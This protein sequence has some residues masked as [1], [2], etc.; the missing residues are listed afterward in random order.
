MKM[1]DLTGMRFGRLVVVAY[2]FS[3]TKNKIKYNFWNC[4]CDC[5]NSVDVL[6]SNLKKG[7]TTSCGCYHLECLSKP[8]KKNKYIFTDK[9][10]IGYTEKEEKFIIDKEDFDLINSF[11]VYWFIEDGYVRAQTE[12]NHIRKRINMHRVIIGAKDDEIV[13]HINTNRADNRRSNLRITNKSNNAIN[14]KPKGKFGLQ[15]VSFH[16]GKYRVNI[17]VRGKRLY[18][19]TYETLEEA[20]NIRITAERN[21]FG[22]FA[23][24]LD[25]NTQSW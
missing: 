11:D 14:C 2:A 13:D 10:I 1:D 25:K 3:K 16:K 12:K 20:M 19:G 7:T 21:F 4:V 5:G 9:Y 15:G 6:A 23:K 17:T 24:S 18:L 8:K 22:E